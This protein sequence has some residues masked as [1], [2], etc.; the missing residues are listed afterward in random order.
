MSSDLRTSFTLGNCLFGTVKL[1]KNADSD[2]HIYRGY[3][4]EHYARLQFSWSDSSWCKISVLSLGY[5]GINSFLFFNTTKTNQFKAKES[6]KNHICC[7]SVILRKILQS[8][9]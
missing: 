8:I 2:K 3:I 1:T 6:E 9:T 4:I 5:N 7:V